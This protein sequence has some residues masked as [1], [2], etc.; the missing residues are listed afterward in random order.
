M[1]IY[2]TEQLIARLVEFDRDELEKIVIAILRLKLDKTNKTCIAKIITNDYVN[3]FQ[4]EICFIDGEDV[5]YRELKKLYQSPFMRILPM[6]ISTADTCYGFNTR[7]LIMQSGGLSF[8]EGSQINKAHIVQF[9]R[10]LRFS[11]FTVKSRR[12]PE[13]GEV[14]TA[15]LKV[16]YLGTSPLEI[17]DL[18]TKQ[19]ERALLKV[20]TPKAEMFI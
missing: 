5:P 3:S 9:G 16:K 20:E 11:G 19:I 8:V 14:D 2:T 12:S 7:E 17:A 18:V 4:K 13:S 15:W 10:L 1:S 6:I